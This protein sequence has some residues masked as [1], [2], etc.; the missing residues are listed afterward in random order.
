MKKWLQMLPALLSRPPS[1][2]RSLAVSG[3]ISLYSTT[4]GTPSTWH[5]TPTGS[6]GYAFS[7]TCSHR[8]WALSTGHGRAEQ[9]G[10]AR[11]RG[12]TWHTHLGAT[13]CAPKHAKTDEDRVRQSHQYIVHAVHVHK[14]H[15]P[16]L[17][18]L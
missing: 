4:W 5:T 7:T 10:G 1:G 13:V 14:L 18:V 3:L 15:S 12:G 8:G 11:Q 6:S 2:P 17:H 9:R 16:A